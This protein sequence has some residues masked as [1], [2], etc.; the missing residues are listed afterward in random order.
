MSAP[1]WFENETPVLKE[2]LVSGGLGWDSGQ[3][4]V[5]ALSIESSLGKTEVAGTFD[6]A[7]WLSGVSRSDSI[8]D[9]SV[10]GSVDLTELAK[11]LPESLNLKEQV[12]VTSGVV[13]YSAF[14]KIEGL[15]NRRFFFDVSVANLEAQRGS[16]VISFGKPIRVT[17]AVNNL[18]KNPEIEYATF[19]SDFLNADA[20]GTINRG[21]LSIHGELSSALEKLKQIVELGEAEATGVAEGSIVWKLIPANPE[22]ATGSALDRVEFVGQGTLKQWALVWGD[23][24]R[25]RD[26]DA[27]VDLQVIVT[28]MGQFIDSAESALFTYS[29][30]TDRCQAQ[31]TSPMSI[32][33]MQKS[34]SG[35]TPTWLVHL[36]G[37]LASWCNRLGVGVE[38]LDSQS[39]LGST[40]SGQESPALGGEFQVTGKL[41]LALDELLFSEGTIKGSNVSFRH[42]SYLINEPQVEGGFSLHIDR[43]RSLLSI[44]EVQLA[45]SAF[46]I[47]TE[48]IRIDMTDP[49]STITGT[50][51]Y[52][53][54]VNRV[55]RWKVNAQV[56]D[57]AWFG[58]LR[59]SV[60]LSGKNQV[61]NV[62]IRSECKDLTYAKRKT[63]SS[64]QLAAGATVDWQAVWQEKML[65]FSSD[66][67]FNMGTPDKS[68]IGGT[69][70]VT[71]VQD[72]DSNFGFNISLLTIESNSLGISLGGSVA[73]AAS[74]C[75]VSI[76]GD[77]ACNM[78]QL[79]LLLQQWLGS[80]VT[81]R[82]SSSHRFELRGPLFHLPQDQGEMIGD[83]GAGGTAELKLHL[84]PDN[85]IGDGSFG[86][87][88]GR[89]FGVDV[90]EARIKGSLAASRIDFETI[91]MRMSQGL[92]EVTPQ[93]LLKS[94]GPELF[95]GNESVIQHAMITPQMCR[96][97]LQYVAPVVAQS[98][99]AEGAFSV[100]INQA[101]LPMNNIFDG[102]AQGVLHVHSAKVGPG[103]LGTQLIWVANQVR[104]IASGD[105]SSAVQQTQQQ[106]LAIPKQEVAFHL[107]HH[108][109]SHDRLVL[110]VGDVQMQTSGSVG[111]DQSLN[112]TVSVVI[113]PEWVKNQQLL[114]RFAGQKVQIPI[115]G[116]LQQPKID[117]K[118]LVS[119]S[120][121]MIQ[122]AAGQIIENE[123]RRGFDK[124]FDGGQ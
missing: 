97:W 70:V 56:E 21:E 114:A 8:P 44:G 23:T 51:G 69:P 121:Q 89:V 86:W 113:Q 73:N 19:S 85:L 101:R 11:Q 49:V 78:D 5:D 46:S 100:D 20:A 26:V 40:A 107:D 83:A 91:K 72:P 25:W 119:L 94:T 54:D 64:Q 30:G 84:V 88:S 3:L 42:E 63:P 124:I 10:T 102:H 36:S 60:E 53:A 27:T 1:T 115:S 33:E 92:V 80:D 57:G 17:T 22:S 13:Q 14:S 96:H 95:I 59:G 106:W 87:N 38:G 68:L 7:N 112:M 65:K 31:L 82:G 109:V 34:I 35:E 98:A 105:P 58:D 67:K 111:E 47:G 6:L 50:V 77:L 122:N 39:R 15:D 18:D 41:Q 32:T 117:T 2:V 76:E 12:A 79:S 45:A 62:V 71:S 16:K 116:T 108:R 120:Q 28:K 99:Q 43:P 104:A 123:L 29:S 48:L 24:F 37:G 66:M 118:I 110:Q 103:L 61:L 52:R 90:G 81:L 9:F 93:I 75:D 74:T 4:A 55:G